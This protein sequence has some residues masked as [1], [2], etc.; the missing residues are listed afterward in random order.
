MVHTITFDG[1]TMEWEGSHSRDGG[2]GWC[3]FFLLM[4]W[5]S[6]I[7]SPDGMEWYWFFRIMGWDGNWWD[8]KCDGTLA[9]LVALSH[10]RRHHLSKNGERENGKK[11]NYFS[12]S[13]TLLLSASAN[14]P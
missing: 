14:L 9:W 2:M 6:T 11:I 4:R 1:I 5:D 13:V 8:V 7:I 12:K 3:L 10:R